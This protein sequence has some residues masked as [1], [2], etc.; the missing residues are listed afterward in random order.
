MNIQRSVIKFIFIVLLG[1]IWLCAGTS[2][3]TK[4]EKTFSVGK[5]CSLEISV[6]GG[7]LL[8][9]TWD[10]NEI[11]V[12]V[13]G[14]DDEDLEYVKMTQ[15]GNDV[16]ITYRPKWGSRNDARF[17]MTVPTQCEVDMRTSGGNIELQGNLSA[18]AKGSTSGGDII[19]EKVKGTVTMSTSGGDVKTGDIDG[20]AD[21]HTSGGNIKL[22]SINGEATVST[23][24]GDIRIEKVGKK[25]EA[26]TS[27]GNIEV[28]DIGGDA[29]LSTAGGDVRV[30]KVTGNANLRT[31]GGDLELRGASGT[32]EAKTSGGDI[33]LKNITGSID[34]KTSGG[35]INAELNPS[36]K[37]QSTLKSSGGDIHLF[38]TENAKATIEA[39]IRLRE[40]WGWSSKKNKY[41][42]KSDFKA[43]TYDKR[44]DNGYGD[45]IHATYLLNGG[46][47][48]ISLETV[49]GN[50]EI[51]K[52]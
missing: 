48:S 28:G 39:M 35:N 23:S 13:D 32:V 22:A 31:A 9:K 43:D 21:L 52:K 2:P 27:G 44:G 29:S 26:R 51:R 5:T 15:T 25:L 12:F 16:R 11:N 46:G 37:G 10:K 30:G 1:T 19:I 33:D 47:E 3:D 7:D 50:I 17:T 34:A 8:V 42:I 18:N 24:G 40:D 36:G 38:I 49:N 6:S 4:Q 20:K 41:D 14:L 45:E